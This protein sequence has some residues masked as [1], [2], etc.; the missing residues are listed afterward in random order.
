MINLQILQVDLH[1]QFNDV[2][3]ITKI[4]WD[5]SGQSV[6]VKPPDTIQE[7]EIVLLKRSREEL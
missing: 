2:C 6:S 7:S 4:L 5:F 3:E 1:S